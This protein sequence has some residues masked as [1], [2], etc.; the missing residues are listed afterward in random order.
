MRPKLK[1]KINYKKDIETFFSFNRSADY[2]NGRTLR[3]AFFRMYPFLERYRKGNSLRISQ[4][5]ITKFIKLVYQK[6]MEVMSKNMSLYQKNWREKEKDFYK[7]TA[8]LFNDKFWP[9]EKYIAYSTIWGMYPR[10]LED[11]TFQVPYKYKNRKY[12]NVII[13]H[14]ML[15]FIFY[16]YFSKEYPK[17]RFDKYNLFVWHISEIFNIIVQNSPKWLKVFKEKSKDYPEHRKIINKL[18]NKYHN[19]KEKEWVVDDLISD[20]IESI[21][22]LNSLNLL[23]HP[24]K[25]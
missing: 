18:K 12:I 7:L 24:P 13:A 14:E 1:F 8:Q 17:Y 5:K 19:K 6:K 21:R 11:K 23:G 25:K 22:K 4:E 15:H 20:I 3:W 10:F 9:K 2:D 16:N